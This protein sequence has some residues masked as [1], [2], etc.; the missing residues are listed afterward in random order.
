MSRLRPLLSLLFVAQLLAPGAGRASVGYQC[1]MDNTVHRSCCC[2]EGM[3][4][5][6]SCSRVHAADCCTVRP[7][8]ERQATRSDT[9]TNLAPLLSE[10]VAWTPAALPASVL[11]HRRCPLPGALGPP[12][13]LRNCT[14]LR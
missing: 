3:Q 11:A 4:R 12:I 6:S 8:A 7:G 2:D 9:S 1:E 14:L 10:V 5:P 13:F